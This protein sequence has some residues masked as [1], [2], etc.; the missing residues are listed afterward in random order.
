MYY[1]HT[2]KTEHPFHTACMAAECMVGGTH[3]A[4]RVKVKDRHGGGHT[5]TKDT[6]TCALVGV[7]FPPREAQGRVSTCV[8][9]DVGRRWSN[10]RPPG[11]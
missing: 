2:H 11:G 1:T 5:K 3:V 4:V 9:G 6:T 10:T 7:K 8:R